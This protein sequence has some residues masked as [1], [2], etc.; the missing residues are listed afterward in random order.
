[1]KILEV[2]GLCK[3]YP[4]F[5]LDHV[6]FSLEKGRIM[7][8]IGRNGAGKT[9]TLKALLNFIHP[10]DGEIL[11][12]GEGFR[13]HEMD[14]KERIG[15]VSGGIDY[16]AKKKLSTITSV[17]RRFYRAWDEAAYRQYMKEFAL[18]ENKTPDQLS[19]GMKVT[20]GN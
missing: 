19:A 7:G 18:D 2:S 12:F 4:A 9:T 10:D 11:F 1:M 16:Y 14:I 5:C 17:T 6:S 15:F 20:S 3:N 13:E 8:F